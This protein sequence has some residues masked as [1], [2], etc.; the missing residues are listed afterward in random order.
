MVKA[1]SVKSQFIRRTLKRPIVRLRTRPPAREFWVMNVHN[2]PWQ[3][4]KLRNKAVKVQIAKIKNLETK[5]LPVFYVGDFNE[6]KT[7]LCK[8]LKKT[9]LVSASGGRLTGKGECMTPRQ[10]RVDWIFGSKSVTWSGFEFTK[11]PLARLST[12]HWV[13][14]VDVVVP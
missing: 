1:R 7:I 8:V 14:V 10:M 4:Q 11:P 5:G 12:D 2:A 13:P 3:Y 9:G 6:K